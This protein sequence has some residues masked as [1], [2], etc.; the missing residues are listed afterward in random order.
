MLYH[1]IIIKEYFNLFKILFNFQ[2]KGTF[3]VTYAIEFITCFI[4]MQPNDYI[5]WIFT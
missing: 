3:F 4:N 5:A 2:I 1:D